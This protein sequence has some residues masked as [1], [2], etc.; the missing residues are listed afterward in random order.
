MGFHICPK[1]K[2]GFTHGNEEPFFSDHSSGDNTLT[3]SNGNAWA[4]PD[5]LVYYIIDCGWMPPKEFIQ[6]IMNVDASKEE[7]KLDRIQTK[8]L[9]MPGNNKKPE[10]LQN[11][12]AIGMGYINQDDLDQA[13]KQGWNKSIVEFKPFVQ[14]L[15]DVYPFL[16]ELNK[17]SLV[18]EDIIKACD[19]GISS[20]HLSKKSVPIKPWRP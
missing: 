2:L 13:R 16:L 6:D 15:F 5:A 10:Y 18:L 3:F 14:K 9:N 12:S 8:G 1:P 19:K 17:S 11:D 4:F 20:T 7:V